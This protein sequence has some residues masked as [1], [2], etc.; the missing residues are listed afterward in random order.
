MLVYA[1]VFGRNIPC[2]MD[3]N[4]CENYTILLKGRR[5]QNSK[6]ESQ[7]KRLNLQ[8]NR[9][10]IQLLI[11]NMESWKPRLLR[12]TIHIHEC[13]FVGNGETKTV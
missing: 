6:F 13:F 9:F 5:D 10:N 4:S 7:F 8:N 3:N 12:K 1:D 11:S 2:V